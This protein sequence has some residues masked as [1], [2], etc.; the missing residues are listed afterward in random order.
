MKA[1]ER[2][3]AQGEAL[4]P[5]FAEAVFREEAAPEKVSDPPLSK[6]SR[7]LSIYHLLLHCQGWP[8]DES[9]GVSKNLLRECFPGSDKTFERDMALLRQAG[10]NVRFSRE[11]RAYL[12]YPGE[13]RKPHPPKN[14]AE[15]RFIERVRR[16][17]IVLSEIPYEDCDVW[18][19]ETFSGVSRRTMQRDFAALNALG[20]EIQYDR[21]PGYELWDEDA[22]PPKKGRYHCDAPNTFDLS[23]FKPTHW[24]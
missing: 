2:F 4:A 24:G 13:P 14:K 22:I 6:L 21:W 9:R 1:M 18:Y 19:R 20:Y 16:L 17:C 11:Y 23:T 12:L 15:A 7:V 8:G 3:Q 10:V 5:R